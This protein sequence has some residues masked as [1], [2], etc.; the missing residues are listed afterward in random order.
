V[1]SP[2]SHQVTFNAYPRRTTH[3]TSPVEEAVDTAVMAHTE[4]EEVLPLRTTAPTLHQDD[5]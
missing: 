2:A 3:T 5:R 1:C 4:A